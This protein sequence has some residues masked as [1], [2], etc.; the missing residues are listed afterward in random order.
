MFVLISGILE[1]D[2][3]IPAGH[4]T[5]PSMAQVVTRSQLAFGPNYARLQAIKKEYDP[6]CIFN[7]LGQDYMTLELLYAFEFQSVLSTLSTMLRYRDYSCDYEDRHRSLLPFLVPTRKDQR[8]NIT[9]EIE[10]QSKGEKTAHTLEAV[11][12]LGWNLSGC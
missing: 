12:D 1:T 6:E 11:R 8:W 7:L 4:I 10:T 2:V 3:E 5:H 9:L